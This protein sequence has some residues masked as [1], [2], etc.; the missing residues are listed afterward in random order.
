MRRL[1]PLLLPLL[2][3]TA[4]AEEANGELAVGKFSSENK[5]QIFSRWQPYE[6]E[7]IKAHSQ[8]QL[9]Q[10]GGVRVIKA[11][12]RG[13]ASGLIQRLDVDLQQY[14]ILS[15][16]WK[17]TERPRGK[18]DRKRSED[19]HAARIYLIFNAPEPNESTLKWLWRQ[20]TPVKSKTTHAINYIWAHSAELGKPIPNP[21]TGSAMMIPVN[22]GDEMLNAWV[23]LE[24]NILADYQ[25][26]FGGQPPKLSAI[27]IMTDSDN[28]RSRATAF[29]GDIIFSSLDK[30]R[31]NKK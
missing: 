3:H 22:R 2:I 31:T 7:K 28:S 18:D 1:A 15:W 5:Q 27:A 16:R 11:T 20:L 26:S 9:V 23:E 14:P 29:Y 25:A 30:N 10:E 24:R 21:F 4:T 13:S 19:D 17:V 8:Y 12:S 6:F